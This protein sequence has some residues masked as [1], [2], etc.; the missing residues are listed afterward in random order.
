MKR[1]LLLFFI[2][3]LFVSF[4]SS[5]AYAG[6]AL[7]LAKQK[8]KVVRKIISV[9]TEKGTPAHTAKEDKLRVEINQ[10]FDFK[11]LTRRA[12]ARHWE[13]ESEADLKEFTDTLQALIEK[14]YLLKAAGKADY[15]VKWFPQVKD[16]DHVVVRHKLKSGTHVTKIM[17]KMM[18]KEGRWVVF[19]MVI[20]DVSL[21]ENYKAQFNRI[22][23]KKGF[24]KLL[25][26]MKKKLKKKG[27]GQ[28]KDLDKDE[29]QAASK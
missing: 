29:Q 12:L 25:E 14:N 19:D 8:E 11:E 23:N 9:K 4:A 7:Q 1:S 15:Q 16:A 24:A 27:E 21:L 26:K 6:T 13:G 28:K 10:L 18:Q 5:F 20:D 2:V 17:Y 22:I 3:A